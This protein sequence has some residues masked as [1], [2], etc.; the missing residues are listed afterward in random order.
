MFREEAWHSSWENS[1][2]T[3]P[4]GYHPVAVMP[5]AEIAY[6]WVWKNR[7]PPVRSLLQHPTSIN[8]QWRKSLH[9]YYSILRTLSLRN[10]GLSTHHSSM[11][12]FS[13]QES[14]PTLRAC[15]MHSYSVSPL[16]LELRT[17]HTYH[18]SVVAA[19]PPAIRKL[20]PLHGRGFITQLLLNHEVSGT[21]NP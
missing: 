14:L 17:H 9:H 2:S 1:N 15:Y 21:I 20:L 5:V 13:A 10:W 6:Q 4:S 8:C 18:F 3:P 12:H 7:Q 19:S 16:T 11:S